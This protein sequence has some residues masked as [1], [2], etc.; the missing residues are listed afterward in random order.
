MQLSCT[1]FLQK[2][3]MPSK[4]HPVGPRFE[5]QVVWQPDLLRCLHDGS[6]LESG[7]R[8][9][10]FADHK[11]AGNDFDLGAHVVAGVRFGFK[12]A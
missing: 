6:E 11:L 8:P 3:E 10:A 1:R 7:S 9:G 2:L 4:R 5:R 12:D